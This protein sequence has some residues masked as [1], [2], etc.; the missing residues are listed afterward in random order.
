MLKAFEKHLLSSKASY[1][2]KSKALSHGYILHVILWV[3]LNTLG[4]VNR[5]ETSI[6]NIMLLP[7]TRLLKLCLCRIYL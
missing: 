7:D 3:W 1:T 6:K 2:A 4:H 5:N